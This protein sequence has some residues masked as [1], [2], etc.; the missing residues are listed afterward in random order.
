M[1]TIKVENIEE[2]IKFNPDLNQYGICCFCKDD[3]NI[4]SQSC[5]KCIR[6]II[7]IY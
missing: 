6:D 7:F 3:C 5:G 1:D 2:I 4:F